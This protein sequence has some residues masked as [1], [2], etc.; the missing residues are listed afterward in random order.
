MKKLTPLMAIA[1]AGIL[2]PEAK[3]TVYNETNDFSGNGSSPTVWGAFNPL[4]DGI[5]GS[6]NNSGD[7]SDIILF[8]GTA[9]TLITIPFTFTHTTGFQYI[10]IGIYDNAGYVSP[11]FNYAFNGAASGSTNITFTV[12]TDGTYMFS[13]GNE[14]GSFNYTLGAV[15][16]P[17]TMGLMAAGA[18]GA[19][20][21]ARRRK[22]KTPPQ[23]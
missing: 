8:N 19:V 12:P 14:G 7:F 11:L 3:A 16:E 9:S 13:V 15:P 6:I 20:A 21:L 1:M 10:F 22:A 18:V 23:P 17:G 4:T 2:A 5:V